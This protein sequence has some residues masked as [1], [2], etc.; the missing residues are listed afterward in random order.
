MISEL[1]RQTSSETLR[2][3]QMPENILCN[4]TGF[5]N[6]VSTRLHESWSPHAI[7]SLLSLLPPSTSTQAKSTRR[8]THRPDLKGRDRQLP[9]LRHNTNVDPQ[10]PQH[11][12]NNPTR[13][14]EI[15][16][17]PLHRLRPLLRRQTHLRQRSEHV[18]CQ[19][20]D[21]AVIRLQV[22]DLLLEQQQPEVFAQEFY[23][24]ERRREER[25]RGER[26]SARRLRGG[27]VGGRER[28]RLRRQRYVGV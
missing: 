18:I 14:P 28:S 20:V 4:R 25:A 27:G 24:V 10:T 6:V 21:A 13:K 17:R 3:H 19:H 1:H 12:S 2:K 5:V 15:P 7:L 26:R 22:V 11:P 8:R 16:L 23:R 9:R